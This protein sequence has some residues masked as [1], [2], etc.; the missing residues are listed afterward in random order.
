MAS[1]GDLK[2]ILFTKY[3]FTHS[4][5]LYWRFL[6]SVIFLS[7]EIR[8]S[9]CFKN[10]QNILILGV[11]LCLASGIF[12]NS[13]PSNQGDRYFT[14]LAKYRPNFLG[15]QFACLRPGRSETVSSPSDT[16]DWIIQSNRQWPWSGWRNNK[17]SSFELKNSRSRSSGDLITWHK[18]LG[19]RPWDLPAFPTKN[20]IF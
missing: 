13:V 8:K 2:I 10:C 12:L 5:S 17:T 15:T 3:M 11:D 1:F 14:Y 6:W 18:F 20:P 19:D 16:G 7:E 9:E 4:F